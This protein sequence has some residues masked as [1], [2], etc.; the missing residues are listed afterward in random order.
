LE[1]IETRLDDAFFESMLS[2]F[3]RQALEKIFAPEKSS[4]PS[5]SG[6]V[7]L[8]VFH[9]ELGLLLQNADSRTIFPKVLPEV[10]W[11]YLAEYVEEAIVLVGRS[12]FRAGCGGEAPF[13][14]GVWPLLPDR[15]ARAASLFVWT[16]RF[17][18]GRVVVLR[19]YPE[20]HS[21]QDLASFRER[22]G[23]IE[24]LLR[25]L[26]DRWMLDATLEVFWSR[27]LANIPP[28]FTPLRGSAS[29]EWRRTVPLPVTPGGEG[30]KE[31][32]LE[33]DYWKSPGEG[34]TR[35]LRTETRKKDPRPL[36]IRAGAGERGAS[37][38]V[39]VNLWG[40]FSLGTVLFPSG[41]VRNFDIPD[42]LVKLRR[43]RALALHSLYRHLLYPGRLS[44]LDF[45]VP[46]AEC[47]DLALLGELPALLDPS[48]LE[49]AFV[50]LILPSD[51]YRKQV[52]ERLRPADL[53]FRNSR[54][55]GRLYLH[56]RYCP[57]EQAKASVFPR[58]LRIEGMSE[59]NLDGVV[60]LREYLASQG[61]APALK[62]KKTHE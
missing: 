53:L 33:G 38:E 40:L 11:E 9:R 59:Q 51:G 49:D 46:E 31:M 36:Q 20:G 24:G 18:W 32:V 21:E 47:F 3:V 34:W 8:Y 57:P 45:W 60:S 62:G 22:A 14:F 30:E 27:I 35:T 1:W 50:T 19:T 54:K 7:G 12:E 2:P 17:D 15:I 55:P 37:L 26:L 16:G 10:S 4:A 6:G 29:P 39:P 5:G 23:E 41:I 44:I 48:V 61:I 56:L 13:F 43:A 25:A 28:R 52:E 42:F 58:I